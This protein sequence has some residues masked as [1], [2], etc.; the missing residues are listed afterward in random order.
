VE[1]RLD[2][3]TVTIIGGKRILDKMKTIYTEKV[4]LDTLKAEGS[5]VAKL[6]LQPASLKVADGS[7]DKVT[8]N[9]VTKERQPVAETEAP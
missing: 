5:L 2:Q 1:A 7:R 3:P 6:A 4:P 8:I 9:Y